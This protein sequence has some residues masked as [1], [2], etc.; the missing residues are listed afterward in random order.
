MLKIA[1]FILLTAF[2]ARAAE[3]VGFRHFTLSQGHDRTLDVAVWY[4]TDAA[5]TPVRQGEDDSFVLQP[6][7]ADAAI[8]H[9]LHPLI[10]LS[11]GYGGNWTNQ[12]WLAVDL[13][14]HGY[15]VAA[16]NHPG[17]TS[18]NMNPSVG[19]RLWERPRD[20]SALLD[21]LTSDPVWSSAIDASRIA[22]IGHSLGGWTVAELAGGRFDPDAFEKDCRDHKELI[23]CGGYLALGVGRDET[24]RAALRQSLQD[25]RIKA[26]VTL[27]AAVTRG[28]DVKSLAAVKIPMLVIAAGSPVRDL[29]AALESRHMASLLPAPTTRYVEIS[30]AVHYSFLPVCVPGA[31][32]HL[33]GPNATICD[34]RGDRESIHKRTRMEIE[35]FLAKV[36][37]VKG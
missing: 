5:G 35:R 34:D 25:A 14:R 36:L 27:D 17:T 1:F 28:F 30:D 12:D 24:S 6:A 21:R 2:P 19:A 13:V 16:A 31:A 32:K 3:A 37:H 29:P 23:S 4:P 9:G 11:H 20:V 33:S 26:G 8:P 10:V 18:S 22:A 15:I 7:I